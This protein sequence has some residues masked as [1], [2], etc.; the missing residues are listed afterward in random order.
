MLFSLTK[1]VQDQWQED[2]RFNP[3][4]R[5]HLVETETT[6]RRFTEPA[7]ECWNSL[8][9]PEC[10]VSLGVPNNGV[11][12]RERLPNGRC[13]IHCAFH[14]SSLITDFTQPFHTDQN[15]FTS[16]NS[17]RYRCRLQMRAWYKVCLTEYR[18]LGYKLPRPYPYDWRSQCNEKLEMRRSIQSSIK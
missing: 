17:L 2:N 6:G 18:I 4:H 16:I 12:V 1:E 7:R 3:C 13:E 9:M 15:C 10:S 8:N 14:A 5:A 11:R